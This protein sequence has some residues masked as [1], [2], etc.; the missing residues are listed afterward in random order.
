MF[1]QIYC[2]CGPLNNFKGFVWN[3]EHV[4]HCHPSIVY[5]S[6]NPGELKPIPSDIGQYSHFFIKASRKSLYLRCGGD[7]HVPLTETSV[8][9]AQHLMT[10]SILKLTFAAFV[11]NSNI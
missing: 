11:G 3:Q 6:P 4:L 9:T 5:C 7:W 2:V 8:K 1:L 10:P